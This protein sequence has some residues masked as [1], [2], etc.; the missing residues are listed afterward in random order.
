MINTVDIDILLRGLQAGDPSAFG[1][2]AVCLLLGLV[3]VAVV[4]V[5]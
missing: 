2:A 5:R 3:A 4:G 1:P